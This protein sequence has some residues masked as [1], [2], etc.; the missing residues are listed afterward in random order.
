M[1]NKSAASSKAAAPA[2]QLGER[3]G[4]RRDVLSNELLGKAAALFAARGFAATSLQDIANEIGLSRTSVYYYFPSKEAVLDAGPTVRGT[5]GT[6][7]AW[8]APSA[9]TW[10]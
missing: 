9:K 4:P 6:C 2:K 1:S 3:S 5:R 7:A 10:I 8:W